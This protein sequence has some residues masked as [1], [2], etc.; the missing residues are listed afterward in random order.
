ML[1]QQKVMPNRLVTED[2]SWQKMIP[3]HLVMVRV[4]VVFLIVLYTM[5]YV[6]DVQVPVGFHNS[7]SDLVWRECHQVR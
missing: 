6:R 4:N 5:I 3:L 7:V 2:T 1:F